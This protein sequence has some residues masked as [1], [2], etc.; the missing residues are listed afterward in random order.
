MELQ[1]LV[2]IT[3]AFFLQQPDTA[4]ENLRRTRADLIDM[5]KREGVERARAEAAFLFV[6]LAFC[7]QVLQSE[8]IVIRFPQHYFEAY[9][10]SSKEL[11]RRLGKSPLFRVAART[12]ARSTYREDARKIASFSTEYQAIQNGISIAESNEVDLISTTVTPPYLYHEVPSE[13]PWW[14]FW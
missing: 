13:R 10:S 4:S 9:S 3:V 8:D 12:A 5:L 7:R 14:K 11:R 6:P 2:D 1:Q